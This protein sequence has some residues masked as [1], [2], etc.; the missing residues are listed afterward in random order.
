[1]K[2]SVI[3]ARVYGQAYAVVFGSLGW[4]SSIGLSVFG[5]MST[6]GPLGSSNRNRLRPALQQ[7]DPSHRE[8]DVRIDPWSP[9]WWSGLGES[10]WPW[11][12]L[13]GRFADT[14]KLTTLEGLGRQGSFLAINEHW[15]RCR[16]KVWPE[17]TPHFRPRQERVRP[18]LTI[19]CH[20]T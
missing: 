2:Q 3:S 20:G 10:E 5:E 19:P 14:V 18:K 6:P 11:C 12:E 15:G 4:G 13:P 7:G 17:R 16:S 9:G 8:T 1:M